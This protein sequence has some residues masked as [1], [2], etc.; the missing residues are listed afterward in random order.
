MRFLRLILVLALV[1]SVAEAATPG[2]REYKLGRK[3]EKKGLP[4]KAWSHYLQARI[5]DPG[6]LTY[7]RS[8][9]RL[10]VAAAQLLAAAGRPA[11]AQ[12]V[13]PAGSYPI[14]EKPDDIA[15]TEQ[16]AQFETEVMRPE[17]RRQLSA[18]GRKC[19]RANPTVIAMLDL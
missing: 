14:A 11:E 13:D 8:A 12:Q 16:D 3:A 6:N 4:L 1:F 19:L 15:I 5:E 17:Q 9:E 18:A 2:A 7:I 10:S